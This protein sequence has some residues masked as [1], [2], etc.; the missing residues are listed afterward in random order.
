[1]GLIADH[2]RDEFGGYCSEEQVRRFVEGKVVGITNPWR[3]GGCTDEVV[4]VV[5]DDTR[6]PLEQRVAE[7]IGSGTYGSYPLLFLQTLGNR[8][9]NCWIAVDGYVCDVT[10]GDDGYDYPGPGQIA[11]LC[12]QDA[13]RHFSDNDLD[14]P[15]PRYLKGG[16]RSS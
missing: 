2:P 13:S 6:A 7:M 1:M 16:L 10:P 8:P 3:D 11:D 4:E 9:D 5:E 14:P 15:P 12:G